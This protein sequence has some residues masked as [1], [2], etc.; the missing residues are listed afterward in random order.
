MTQIHEAPV[1]MPAFPDL[2]DGPTLKAIAQPVLDAYCALATAVLTLAEEPELR[3]RLDIARAQR[4]VAEALLRHIGPI[5]GP[6]DGR[7][8]AGEIG[9]LS[10]NR[11]RS[12]AEA[13]DEGRTEAFWGSLASDIAAMNPS[14]F[15][16]AEGCRATRG[17]CKYALQFAD[18]KPLIEAAEAQLHSVVTACA[19]LDEYIGRA[20]ARLNRQRPPLRAS[21]AQPFSSAQATP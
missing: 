21:A 3:Q 20:Q 12:R 16:L 14:R 6:A 17:A 19:K 13:A 10:T 5:R 7:D 2:V 4:A 9:R 8:L 18:V 1:A 15:A 11:L